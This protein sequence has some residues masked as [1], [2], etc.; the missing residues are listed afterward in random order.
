MQ[1]LLWAYAGLTLIAA[2]LT[3]QVRGAASDYFDAPFG[4]DF[5]EAQN[6]IDAEDTASTVMGLSVLVGIAAAVLFIIW[7]FQMSRAVA[8]YGPHDRKWTPGWA[9]GGWFIPFANC[10]IP[11]LVMVENEKIATAAS[12]SNGDVR[13][14]RSVPVWPGTIIAWCVYIGGGFLVSIASDSLSV[15]DSDDFP[16]WSELSSSYTLMAFALLATAVGAALATFMVRR[17][18]NADHGV[19]P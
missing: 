16:D 11:L 6:W 18:T 1:G 7:T 10:V 4:A 17:S 13:A 5:D 19:A 9:V 3:L 8:R 15:T 14:W 2:V 12:R